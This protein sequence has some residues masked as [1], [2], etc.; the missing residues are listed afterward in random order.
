MWHGVSKDGQLQVEGWSSGFSLWKLWPVCFWSHYASGSDSGA[1][2]AA[3]LAAGPGRVLVLV[4]LSLPA[5]LSIPP[6]PV[7]MP[8]W[9]TWLKRAS[10][11]LRSGPYGCSRCCLGRPRWWPSTLQWWGLSCLVFPEGST[12]VLFF[13]P[14]VEKKR[15]NLL[16]QLKLQVTAL[17]L[18]VKLAVCLHTKGWA[19][20]GAHSFIPQQ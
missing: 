20:N 10:G 3:W 15:F 14:V 16:L 13:Q 8:S 6:V 7:V 2:P 5:R 12:E 19:W 4:T 9:R 18:T 17:D 11:L 1:S